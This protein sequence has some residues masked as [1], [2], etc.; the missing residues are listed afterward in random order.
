MLCQGTWTLSL[1]QQGAFENKG[2]KGKD[3]L[4]SATSKAVV[5][6]PRGGRLQKPETPACLG[7]A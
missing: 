6:G 4:G 5:S 2:H 3:Y 7:G 1:M